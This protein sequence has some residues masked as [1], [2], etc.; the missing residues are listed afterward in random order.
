MGA[1]G[2][3]DKKLNIDLVGPFLRSRKDAT[4]IGEMW[5]VFRMPGPLPPKSFEAIGP[6]LAMLERMDVDRTG[7]LNYEAYSRTIQ[8]SISNTS[9]K[10]DKMGGGGVDRGSLNT[11]VSETGFSGSVVGMDPSSVKSEARILILRMK[12]LN[13]LPPGDP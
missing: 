5:V 12:E 9:H 6:L 13:K 2:K 11:R 4:I 1:K 8:R 10:S 3:M 7:F